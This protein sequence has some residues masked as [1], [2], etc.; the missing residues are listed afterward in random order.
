MLFQRSGMQGFVV[1]QSRPSL[2]MT[3]FTEVSN[4][5]KLKNRLFSKRN[6][7]GA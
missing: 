5:K 7:T 1:A 4:Y 6:G 2:D 3:P